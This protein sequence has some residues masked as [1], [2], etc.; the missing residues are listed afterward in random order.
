[1]ADSLRLV[2]RERAEAMVGGTEDHLAFVV[3]SVELDALAMG[4]HALEVE[5]DRVET[6]YLDRGGHPSAVGRSSSVI[7]SRS[8][9]SSSPESRLERSVVM[10]VHD[11]TPDTVAAMPQVDLGTVSEEP[12]GPIPLFAF[13]GCTGGIASTIGSGPW[14]LHTAGDELLHV[15]R[16]ETHFT[17]REPAGEVTRT[18][19]AGDLAIV[20]RGC[21]H[22]GNAPGGV[23]LLFL[24]PAEGNEYNF[25]D[26][27]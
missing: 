6:R 15:L 14:E 12:P 3:E 21:W 22:R 25:G 11:L 20:P 23:T 16:G 4:C 7:C 27:T 8:G 17:V 2:L 13:H 19:R 10:I 9:S 24:T 18:L 5:D 26:P 1:M